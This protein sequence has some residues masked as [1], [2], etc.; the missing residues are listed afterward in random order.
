MTAIENTATAGGIYRMTDEDLEQEY[1]ASA[2]S[3][4][5]P[6]PGMENNDRQEVVKAMWSFSQAAKQVAAVTKRRRSLKSRTYYQMG[7]S[8]QVIQ[9]FKTLEQ[10]PEKKMSQT[11][12]QLLKQAVVNF[13]VRLVVHDSLT[14]H[15]I[16][17]LQIKI[18]E[19]EATSKNAAYNARINAA[20][21][22]DVYLVEKDRYEDLQ[23]WNE[24]LKKEVRR[25]EPKFKYVNMGSGLFKSDLST[26]DPP[27]VPSQHAQIAAGSA[28]ILRNILTPETSRRTFISLS[29]LTDKIRQELCA[30]LTY[31][32]REHD[33][34]EV[35]K[36]IK[37]HCVAAAAA[38]KLKEH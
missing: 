33:R 10:N 27:G 37:E 38:K 21:S 3:R 31:E 15:E 26:R 19:E 22:E 2:T 5:T 7:V 8:R 36:Q 25:I 13:R 35:V 30:F 28:H 11:D 1:N 9:A 34:E 4:G 16:Q 14:A 32:H 18:Q 20:V 24:E 23:T 17:K 29:S 12:I 6:R